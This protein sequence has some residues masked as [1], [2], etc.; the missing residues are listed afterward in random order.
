MLL[1]KLHLANALI[2][3]LVTVSDIVTV[4]KLLQS[5]PVYIEMTPLFNGVMPVGESVITLESPSEMYL[6]QISFPGIVFD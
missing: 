6:Y 2:P 1:N 5:K 3:I 4:V